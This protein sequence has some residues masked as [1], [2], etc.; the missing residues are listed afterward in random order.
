MTKAG[1][2]R[3]DFPLRPTHPRLLIVAAAVL[4]HATVLIGG[5]AW[6]D[7]GDLEQG[8]AVADPSHW[9]GLFAHGFARTGFYRPLMALSLSWDALVGAPWVFHAEN[10]AWH[11]AAAV[12]VFTVGKEL[13]LSR[14]ADFCSPF[15]RSPRWWW[16]P[17]PTE[18]MRSSW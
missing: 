3:S 16:A 15:I 11:A 1:A 9:A 18:R 12:M 7:H 8:A 13:G 17:S 6:L 10:L 14:R 2:S 5:F 4:A